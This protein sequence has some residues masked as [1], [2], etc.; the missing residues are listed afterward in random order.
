MVQNRLRKTRI[1]HCYNSVIFAA[2]FELILYVIVVSTLL[3]L[4]KSFSFQNSENPICIWIILQKRRINVAHFWQKIPN[5]VLTS[6]SLVQIFQ[7]K[8]KKKNDNNDD[9]NDKVPTLLHSTVLI[10]HKWFECLIPSRHLRV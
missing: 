3:P 4:N 2:N 1:C 6:L 9:N 7:K 5:K 8:K 10:L